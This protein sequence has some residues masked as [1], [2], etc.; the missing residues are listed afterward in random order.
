MTTSAT[1]VKPLRFCLDSFA[2]DTKVGSIAQGPVPIKLSAFALLEDYDRLYQGLPG[3]V[4][5]RGEYRF[6]RPSE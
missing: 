5:D 3:D 4:F 2:A 6:E 1:K